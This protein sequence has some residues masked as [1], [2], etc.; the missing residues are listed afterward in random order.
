MGKADNNDIRM[1][2]ESARTQN[3]FGLTKEQHEQ[4]MDNLERFKSTRV[5]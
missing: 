5:S 3:K 1:L 2:K 4:Y